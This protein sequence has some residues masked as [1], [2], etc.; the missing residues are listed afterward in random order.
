[1]LEGGGL[2][3]VTPKTGPAVG[4]DAFTPTLPPAIAPALDGSDALLPRGDGLV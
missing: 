4:I 2:E 3:A 1:M